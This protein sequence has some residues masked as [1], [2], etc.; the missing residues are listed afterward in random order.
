[1]FYRFFVVVTQTS[2]AVLINIQFS[3]AGTQASTA[4]YITIVYSTVFLSFLHQVHKRVQ[5]CA[6]GDGP[7]GRVGH[8][9]AQ[10]HL[11]QAVRRSGP[12]ST[13]RTGNGNRRQI[14]IFIGLTSRGEVKN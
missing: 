7:R 1:M 8:R 6:G 5:Q 11:L 4:V 9:Q 12:T 2:T 13:S 10:E 3:S 14:C